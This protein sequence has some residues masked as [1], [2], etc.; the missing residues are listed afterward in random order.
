MDKEGGVV[1]GEGEKGHSQSEEVAPKARAAQVDAL[2]ALVA[3]SKWEQAATTLPDLSF[4][5]VSPCPSFSLSIY[6]SVRAGDVRSLRLCNNLRFTF[7]F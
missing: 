2:L 6:R 5:T 3:Q 4:M 1:E 7:G